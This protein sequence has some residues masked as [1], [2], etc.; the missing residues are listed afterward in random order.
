MSQKR[1]SLLLI[2]LS[3][4]ALWAVSYYFDQRE[5]IVVNEGS[6]P[7]QT[8]Q[9]QYSSEETQTLERHNV[10]D[11][12]GFASQ[13]KLVQHYHKHGHEFGSISMEDYLRQAQHLRDRPSG[14]NILEHTRDGGVI[15]R[16]DKHSGAFLAFNRDKTLR[17]YFRPN[18]GEAYCHRQSQRER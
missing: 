6:R 1:R 10:Q 14:G 15:S 16:F 7:A 17:T 9:Q 18:D 5:H 4:A 13:E 8:K 3:L 11:K 2:V 12:I